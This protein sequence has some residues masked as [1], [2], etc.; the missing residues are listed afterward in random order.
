MEIA[1]ILLHTDLQ[2]PVQLMET[3]NQTHTTHTH[4]LRYAGH[5][6]SL[7]TRCIMQLADSHLWSGIFR[8][9]GRPGSVEK[10]NTEVFILLE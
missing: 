8:G 4:T 10:H 3:H 7:F 5:L 2:S 1:V 6:M 9:I